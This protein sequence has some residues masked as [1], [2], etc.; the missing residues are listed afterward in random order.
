M[1]HLDVEQLL[2]IHREVIE[3]TGGSPE[4]RDLGLLESAAAQPRA[5]FGGVELY[6]TIADKAAALGFS[7]ICNHPC[8]DGNKRLGN[9]AMRVFLLMNGYRID[10]SIDEREQVI[11]AVAAGTM[12]REEFTAWLRAHVSPAIPGA[13]PP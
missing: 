8:V 1:N 10:A 2:R 4:V 3:Q 5:A 11:L 6:P 13:T 9:A 7:L 12:K